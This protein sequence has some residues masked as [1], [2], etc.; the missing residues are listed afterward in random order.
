VVQIQDGVQLTV[1]YGLNRVRFPAAVP[2][3]SRIRA[4]ISLLTLKELS[5][6]AG[7]TYAVT[8]ESEQ[9]DKPVCVAEWMVRYYH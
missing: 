7:A 4:R 2:A 5:D 1:N 3:D 9:S 8:V 6:S